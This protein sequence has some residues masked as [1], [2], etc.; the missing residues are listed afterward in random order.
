MRR[1]I[2][3]MSKLQ[4]V[5]AILSAVL[6]AGGITW[7][8]VSWRRSGPKVTAELGVGEVSNHGDARVEF[9]SGRSQVLRLD[10]P[11]GLRDKPVKKPRRKGTKPTLPETTWISCNAIFVRNSGRAPVTVRR[12][13]YI[14]SLGEVNFTFEPQPESSPWGDLLPKRLEAGDEAILVHEKVQM[15]GFLHGVL[16]DHGVAATVFVITLTLGDGR[17]V[18]V[19]SAMRVQADMTDEEFAK[20][21]PW[22]SRKVV[23]STGAFLAPQRR[24]RWLGRDRRQALVM[25]NDSPD[26]NARK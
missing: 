21:A 12:C 16:R 6:A 8:V 3:C 7:A 20:V 25:D 18:F 11:W 14:G 5:F 4:I 24:F 13:R 2:E 10:D 1:Y 23:E 22:I 26:E 17:D 15:R 19:D 9:A